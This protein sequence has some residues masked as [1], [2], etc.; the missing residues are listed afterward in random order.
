MATNPIPD[1]DTPTTYV[2]VIADGVR[3][4]LDRYC[5]LDD[6][7]GT[8]MPGTIRVYDG[9]DDFDYISADRIADHLC[10]EARKQDE[11][12]DE[13]ADAMSTNLAVAKLAASAAVETRLSEFEVVDCGQGVEIIQPGEDAGPFTDLL[14]A[15]VHG[16]LCEGEAPQLWTTISIRD[17]IDQA[18]D[19]FDRYEQVA[20]RIYYFVNEGRDREQAIIFAYLYELRESGTV[21]MFG[22]AVDIRDVFGISKAE[23]RK[24]LSEWMKQF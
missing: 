10:G 19:R 12:I 16:I 22:A 1:P 6:F 23:A 8:D 18:T 5:A 20:D 2:D 4:L 9:G 3:R 14:H 24:H 7:R 11:P 17:E 13:N 21:N 15:R